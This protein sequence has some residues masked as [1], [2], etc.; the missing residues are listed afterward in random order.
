MYSPKT[1]LL[2]GVT[3]FIGSHVATYL[4]KTHPNIRFIGIDK[5]SYCSHIRN[6]DDILHHPNFL[7]I[8]AD[9]TDLSKIEHLFSSHSIDTVIHFAAYTHVDHSFGNSILFTQNNVLGT[10]ILLEVSKRYNIGR[11]IHVSTDE[12]YGSKETVSAE[13]SILDPTNPYAASKAAAE[14]IVKSYYHS[15]K[16]PI[17][18]TRGNNVYGPKQYPEK[19]IPKFCFK[20]INNS[21]CT[22]HGSGG[23]MRSFLY[24][25]DVVKAFEIILFNGKIG[26]IYNI[27]SEKEYSIKEITSHLISIFKSGQSIDDWI[28][29]VKDRDFNDQRYYISSDKL[30]ALGWQPSVSIHEG[31][32][33]TSE[34][35]KNNTTYWNS[36]QLNEFCN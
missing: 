28:E 35:Y 7:F 22:I 32:E 8:Q 31:L 21:K 30:A 11:F 12:V 17:I 34:W 3:G 16:L 23:Q 13:E 15:F 33:L 1:V 6:I 27:G 9:L 29:Y 25:S 19:V 5:M 20:L 10:H 2:T 26:E 24:I 18:I 14:H 4:V 36:S